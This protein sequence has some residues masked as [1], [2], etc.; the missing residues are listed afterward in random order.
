MKY[1]IT[2]EQLLKN[3]NIIEEKT[4]EKE[5]TIE[6]K[7]FKENKAFED[8]E[9]TIKSLE[10][11]KIKEITEKSNN[12]MFTF[13]KNVVYNAVSSIDLKN[14]ELHTAYGCK[15]NPLDIVEKL[16]RPNEIKAIADEVDKLSGFNNETGLIKEIKKQ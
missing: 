13:N 4:G 6:L 2:L 10:P 7:S 11:K 3:K 14:K 16:F 8:G 15:S 1:M 5:M 12:D 9:I